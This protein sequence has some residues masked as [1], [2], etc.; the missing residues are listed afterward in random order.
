MDNRYVEVTCPYCG[1]KFLIDI[2]EFLE[3][4]EESKILA[5]SHKS[6]EIKIDTIKPLSSFYKRKRDGKEIPNLPYP[7]PSKYINDD[8]KLE[9]Y[10]KIVNEGV[11]EIVEVIGSLQSRKYHIKIWYFAYGTSYYFNIAYVI[12]GAFEKGKLRTKDIKY[13]EG[14]PKGLR[15]HPMGASMKRPIR[16]KLTSKELEEVMKYIGEFA[17]TSPEGD[18]VLKVVPNSLNNEDFVKK[19]ILVWYAFYARVDIEGVS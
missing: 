8:E 15:I 10:R 3:S 12:K 14:N 6:T 9:R 4:K 18:V 1:K 16:H 13:I 7:I 5:E 19:L 17:Y 2:N 11:K